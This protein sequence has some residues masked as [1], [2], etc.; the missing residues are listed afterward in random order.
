[1]E[2][3]VENPYLISNFRGKVS[4][5]GRCTRVGLEAV[6]SETNFTVGFGGIDN[7]RGAGT[8]GEGYR[9]SGWYQR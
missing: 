5:G 3:E 9:L 2:L 1:M 7:L 8:A 6:P 4:E